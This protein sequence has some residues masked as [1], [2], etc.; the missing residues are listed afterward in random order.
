MGKQEFRE[1]AKKMVKK[2][3]KISAKS[4]HYKLF[5]SLLNLLHEL[6]ARKILIFNPLA[7]EP[8]FYT[9]KRTLAK[10]YEI[11]VPFMLGISLEMV[12]SRLPLVCAKFGVRE[13]I[14]AKIFKKRIDVAVIPV[15]GVDANM[16]RIGHGRGFY[17]RFFDTLSYK[18][19]V[20]FVEIMDNFT[21]QIITQKHDV[22]CDFYITPKRIYI[23]R[24]IYDRDFY[25]LRSR[26][27][28]AWIRVSGRKK[29][30]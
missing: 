4:S 18:P 8:N 6:K 26:C 1:L 10:K 20:I 13:P 14:S 30:K 12:K 24:G 2:R 16:A 9:L 7:Y 28:G 25:R 5:K 27:G 21:N 11:F 17:D 19:V 29:D 3:A 15:L 23:K 22:V